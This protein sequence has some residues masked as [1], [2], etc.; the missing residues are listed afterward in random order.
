MNNSWV[1]F[2]AYLIGSIPFS[3]LVG[4]W[5]KGIDIRQCGSG[6]VGTTNVW[7]T[8]GPVA[9]IIALAGD[10]GKG[11]LAVILARHFGGPWLVT[12][13]GAAVLAGHS[14]PL[15]L[16]FKGGKL[17]ATA[18]GVF[19]AVSFPVLACTAV[20][21][22]VLVGIF[23]YISLASILGIISIPILMAAFHLDFPYIL[24]GVFAAVFAVYKHIPN[25]KRLA[26][27]T[28]PKINL[29]KW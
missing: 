23:R 4:R 19:A 11:V 7:R 20:I 26:N 2:V 17:I 8:A 25:M 18:A 3:F 24:L 21:W 12:L 27:G 6:N 16:G 9:G 15:F 28:E 14:W 5:W 13:A 10:L 1:I 22:F 29:K